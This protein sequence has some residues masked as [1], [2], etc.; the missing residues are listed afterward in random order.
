MFS[1]GA[2]VVA[3]CDEYADC[4]SACSR[5]NNSLQLLPVKKK[6]PSPVSDDLNKLTQISYEFYTQ[7]KT[8]IT[9][10]IHVAYKN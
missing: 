10:I 9:K 3:D 5:S 1:V 4:D 6:F 8:S 2:A 7:E